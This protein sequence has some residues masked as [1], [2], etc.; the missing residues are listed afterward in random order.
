MSQTGNNSI[1]NKNCCYS[2]IDLRSISLPLVYLAAIIISYT[3]VFVEQVGNLYQCSVIC[4]YLAISILFTFSEPLA[5][6]NLA[7]SR[8]L[9]LQEVPICR[10]LVDSDL[11]HSSHPTSL[12]HQQ[13][14]G[15]LKVIEKCV[16]GKNLFL[17]EDRP[18]GEGNYTRTTEDDRER[19]LEKDE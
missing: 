12:L 2:C 18:A 9:V 19:Q 10:S 7:G 1:V 3:N 17:Q 5:S 8:K 13:Q 14:A 6:L 11:P 4:K 15:A 16:F